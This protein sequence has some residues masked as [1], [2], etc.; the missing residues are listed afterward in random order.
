MHA[1]SRAAGGRQALLSAL[2]HISFRDYAIEVPKRAF[3][4][5]I[6]PDESQQA[7]STSL[8]C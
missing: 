5:R 4:S 8:I 7:R 6:H 3:S 1:A 2:S